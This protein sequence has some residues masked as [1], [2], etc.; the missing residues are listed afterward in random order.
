MSVVVRASQQTKMVY[1]NRNTFHYDQEDACNVCAT[2]CV[3]DCCNKC[4]EAVCSSDQCCYVFP[5]Y[6]NTAFVVCRVCCDR[7]DRKLK[8]VVDDAE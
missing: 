1:R 4:G 2:N 8:A 6:K 3:D 7:I 5:Y